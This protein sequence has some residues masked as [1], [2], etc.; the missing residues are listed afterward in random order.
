MWTIVGVVVVIMIGLGL[1]GCWAC[2]VMVDTINSA[3]D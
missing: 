3:N 1:I 2:S